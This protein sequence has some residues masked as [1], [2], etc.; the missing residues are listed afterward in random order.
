MLLIFKKKLKLMYM[1]KVD[2]VKKVKKK[3]QIGRKIDE[4]I[5]D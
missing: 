1:G 4:Q 3:I 5:K 2:M